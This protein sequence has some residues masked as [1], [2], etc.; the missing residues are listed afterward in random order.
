MLVANVKFNLLDRIFDS[1][2]LVT[3]L[4]EKS[5]DQLQIHFKLLNVLLQQIRL[6]L[7]FLEL[8]ARFLDR[9]LRALVVLFDPCDL[10]SVIDDLTIK[11]P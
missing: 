4:I 10:S 8:P 5:I 9:K 3:G 1:L 7:S 2:A 11:L 6:G